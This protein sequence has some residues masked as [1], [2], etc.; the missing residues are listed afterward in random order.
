MQKIKNL[1]EKMCA[2][3][4]LSSPACLTWLRIFPCM[5][6][7]TLPAC[8]KTRLTKVTVKN[9]PNPRLLQQCVC[10]WEIILF[11]IGVY[12]RADGR[13]S[14]Q[15]EGLAVQHHAWPCWSPGAYTLLP[16][17][18]TWSREQLDEALDQCCCLEVVR[19][20]WSSAR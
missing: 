9:L 3:C 17:D 2:V 15:N 19:L 13:F 8:L 4:F 12:C 5:Y 18:G 11:S 14:T 1:I 10:S 7:T 6:L 20:G 16:A